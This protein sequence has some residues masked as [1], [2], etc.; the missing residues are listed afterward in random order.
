M[1]DERSAGVQAALAGLEIDTLTTRYIQDLY[2]HLTEWHQEQQRVFDLREQE[3]QRRHR[4]VVESEKSRE[5]AEAR[6]AAAWETFAVEREAL[7]HELQRGAGDRRLLDIEREALDSKSIAMELRD[8][9]NAELEQAL[10]D[11]EVEVE[12]REKAV[13]DGESQLIRSW[14]TL[15]QEE[16]RFTEYSQREDVQRGQQS[17]SA[18]AVEVVQWEQ[19]MAETAQ[20]LASAMAAFAPSQSQEANTRVEDL[21]RRERVVA[22]A[23]ARLGLKLPE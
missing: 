23:E 11:R 10:G 20:K 16:Q 4:E 12:M 7:D 2:H 9:Q 8:A 18:R 21:E 15:S 13:K 22:Q 19:G 6:L 17:L 1:S 3:L 5:R 14:E